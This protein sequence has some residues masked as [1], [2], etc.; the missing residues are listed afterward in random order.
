MNS[1]DKRTKMVIIFLGSWSGI[2][3]L[4]ILGLIKIPAFLNERQR[5][6]SLLAK[7]SNQNELENKMNSFLA[8][9]KSNIELINSDIASRKELLDNASFTRLPET[10]ISAFV[11]GLPQLYASA[12]VSLTNLSYKAREKTGTF[13]DMPFEAQVTCSYKPLRQLLHAIESHKAGIRIEEFEIITL[14]D[15]SH[16]AQIRMLCNV[17]FKTLE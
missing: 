13:I 5:L 8:T 7:I 1:T 10:E 14:D 15:V 9:F 17:R 11:D 12:G 6:S 2:V 16:K 3:L 4:T